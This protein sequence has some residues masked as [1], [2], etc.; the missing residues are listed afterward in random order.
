[1]CL[2]YQDDNNSSFALRFCEFDSKLRVMA[3]PV[4][5]KKRN[6]NDQRHANHFYRS[7]SLSL[8]LTCSCWSISVRVSIDVFCS[9]QWSSILRKYANT[10]RNKC[11]LAYDYTQFVF[12][13]D[14]SSIV[15]VRRTLFFFASSVIVERLRVHRPF[16]RCLATGKWG[17]PIWSCSVCVSLCYS[18]STNRYSQLAPDLIGQRYISEVKSPLLDGILVDQQLCAHACE[19]KW[20]TPL[21][22]N[23]QKFRNELISRS[24]QFRIVQNGV[25]YS[26]CEC[27]TPSARRAKKVLWMQTLNK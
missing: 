1:M 18:S 23:C 6:S 16:W 10:R 27:N 8:S 17:S 21:L 14:L 15:M 4:Q 5:K 19:V 20:A 26:K 22:C 2:F 7:P 24:L 3:Q 12:A 11:R 9:P 25:F 13:N